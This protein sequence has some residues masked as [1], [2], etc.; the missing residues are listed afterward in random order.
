LLRKSA[1]RSA[2]DNIASIADHARKLPLSFAPA[3]HV[4]Q[5]SLAAAPDS[6]ID[7]QC[8]VAA[9][10]DNL[11]PVASVGRIRRWSWSGPATKACRMRGRRRRFGPEYL[12]Q[13][14]SRR[15]TKS[16]A[17]FQT[18][19]AGRE[20][21]FVFGRV[22]AGERQRRAVGQCCRERGADQSLQICLRRSRPQRDRRRMSA[23]ERR[24]ST[25]YS[26][27]TMVGLPAGVT[28][29]V[30][31]RIAALVVQTFRENPKTDFNLE[32]TPNKGFRVTMNV[33]R[34]YETRRNGSL[35]R[36]P[37]NSSQSRTRRNDC[38]GYASVTREKWWR[39]RCP[40]D[41]PPPI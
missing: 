20:F 23:P 2:R 12:R 16:S 11:L 34:K 6:R 8:A 29:P 40:P 3:S 39:V 1:T 14:P 35:C 32:S 30:P 15:G 38:W 22:C 9:G 17:R 33:D 4:P 36:P 21:R 13:P 27:W 28:W 10:S 41:D 7:A 26:S 24:S 18:G 31:R 5:N 19:H 37:A 25:V